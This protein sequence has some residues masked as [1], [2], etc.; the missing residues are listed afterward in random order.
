MEE[1]AQWL[2]VLI[3]F[4]EDSDF[5]LKIHIVVYKY[6]KLQFQGIWCLLTFVGNTHAHSV[7]AVI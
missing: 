1:I 2:R 4:E 6:P 7:H 3:A 5:V